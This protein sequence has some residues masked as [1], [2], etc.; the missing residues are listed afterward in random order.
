MTDDHA[1]R[2]RPVAPELVGPVLAAL[3][4]LPLPMWIADR[5]GEVRWLKR[6]RLVRAPSARPARPEG[7]PGLGGHLDPACARRP[8]ST[9]A[10]VGRPAPEA[11]P[12][13]ASRWRP[14]AP[15]LTRRRPRLPALTPRQHKV[16]TL[17]AQGQ[18]TAQIAA[19]LGIAEETA[20]NHVRMLL[21][22]LGVHTRLEA[23]VV[24]FRSGWL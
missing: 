1:D 21:G 8:V 2:P 15:P 7:A 3:D 20:R 11:D 5:A 14:R 10:S 17:L 23:V 4:V 13:S 16:L 24:A 9:A 19:S 22:Q 6:G 12:R 18:T